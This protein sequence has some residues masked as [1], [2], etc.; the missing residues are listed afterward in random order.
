MVY[1]GLDV[2]DSDTT[3]FLHIQHGDWFYPVPV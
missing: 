2:T 1:L 3:W